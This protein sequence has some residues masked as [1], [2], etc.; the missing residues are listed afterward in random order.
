MVFKCIACQ[1]PNHDIS[2][3]RL[4]QLSHSQ[5]SAKSSASDAVTTAKKFEDWLI[6]HLVSI[7]YWENIQD[8]HGSPNWSNGPNS[9]SPRSSPH[10]AAQKRPLYVANR[11]DSSVFIDEHHFPVLTS[12]STSNSNDN[13][14]YSCNS[15]ESTG[16]GE[17]ND[18][19]SVH[20][21]SVTVFQCSHTSVFVVAPVAFL[22]VVGCS[23]CVI[24]V[25]VAR[26]NVTVENCDHCDIT[27]GLCF[28]AFIQCRT[29]H[30]S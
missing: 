28:F 19:S 9:P 13:G 15:S 17:C 1:D 30:L 14:K 11:S 23:N 6:E 29:T 24:F 25:S 7:P 16:H 2:L 20:G 4:F 5:N 26:F 21:R 18:N 3:L 10:L 8:V 27:V 22:R 12:T